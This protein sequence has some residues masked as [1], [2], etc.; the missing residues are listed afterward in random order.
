MPEDKPYL[1]KIYNFLNTAYGKEGTVSKGAFTQSYQDFES[2]ISSND[3]YKDKIYGALSNA[4][5]PSGVVR[6]NAFTSTLEAFRGKVSSTQP[7][8]NIGKVQNNIV[9]DQP[10]IQPSDPLPAHP[11]NIVGSDPVNTLLK[12]A[13]DLQ[14]PETKQPGIMAD[15]SAIEPLISAKEAKDQEM[16]DRGK[17]LLLTPKANSAIN[18]SGQPAVPSSAEMSIQD[19]LHKMDA[20]DKVL[21]T[22]QAEADEFSKTTAG[23]LYY[24]FVRPVYQSLVGT[25][26][27]LLAGTARIAGDLG[28]SFGLED[29]KKVLDKTADGLADY[30]DFNRL[31]REGNSTGYLNMTPTSQQG[32]MSKANILPKAMESITSMATLIGGGRVL[33]GNSAALYT[34]NYLATYEDFRK[35]AKQAGLSNTDADKF[36]ITSAGVNSALLMISPETFMG[37]SNGLPLAEKSVFDAIKSGV[38]VQQAVKNGIKNGLKTIGEANAIVLSTDIANRVIRTGSDLVTGQNN[39][40]E[41]SITPTLDEALETGVLTTIAMGALNGRKFGRE[42]APSSLERSA[43]V[44]AAEKPELIENAINKALETQSI[45]PAQADR[46][47]NDVAEY[48]EIYNKIKEQVLPNNPRA[49]LPRLALDAFKSK[50]QAEE[51]KPLSSIPALSAVNERI[52]SDQA[53]T[54]RDIQD[55]VNGI[56]DLGEKVSG[57]DLMNVFTMQGMEMDP[58]LLKNLGNLKQEYQ[59]DLINLDALYRN[60][61]QFRSYVDKGELIKRESNNGID[62]L[63]VINENGEIL[64]GINGLAKEY[65]DGKKN[66][67]ALL[68][69]IPKSDLIVEEPNSSSISVERNVNKPRIVSLQPDKPIISVERLKAPRIVEKISSQETTGSPDIESASDPVT[70]KTTRP[71]TAEEAK[72]RRDNAIAQLKD[73]YERLNSESAEGD[74]KN[75]LSATEQSE[76]QQTLYNAIREEMSFR[77]TAVGGVPERV[78]EDIRQKTYNAISNEVKVNE[79]DFNNA[80]ERIYKEDTAP[81]Q[82]ESNQVSQLFDGSKTSAEIATALAEMTGDNFLSEQVKSLLPYLEAN[83][84]IKFSRMYTLG[85]GEAFTTG[86]WTVNPAFTK[87]KKALTYATVHELYHTISLNELYNNQAFAD[88]IGGLVSKLRDQLG[89]T[90]Y[91]EGVDGYNYASKKNMK[92]YGLLNSAEFVSEIFSNKEFSDV[93]DKTEIGQKKPILTRVIDYVKSAIGISSKTVSSSDKIRKMILSSIKEK[94]DFDKSGDN[95]MTIRNQKENANPNNFKYTPEP[96]KNWGAKDVRDKALDKLK[97]AYNAL[98]T[99]G[100]AFDPNQTAKKQAEFNKALV[101]YIKE[102][103]LYRANQVKGFAKYTKTQVKTAV[104]R[105]MNAEGVKISMAEYTDLFND[106]YSQI[107]KIPGVLGKNVDRVT[108][109]EYFK[110]KIEAREKGR[111]E[112]FTEGRAKGMAEGKEKGLEQG[113]RKGKKEGAIEARERVKIVRGAINEVL[114]ESRVN[115][116]MLQKRRIVSMLEQATTSRDLKK[117]IDRAVDATTQMVWEQKHKAV[118]SN[119][120]KQIKAVNALKRSKSM[121][122]QDIEWLKQLQLPN[123]AKVDDLNTYQDMLKDYISSRKGDNTNPKYTKEEIAEFIQDENER[124]YQEKRQG[125]QLDMEG[126]KEKGVLPDDISL[127]E[128]IATLDNDT[129]NKLKEGISKKAEILRTET[130]SR[131]GY[132][133]DRVAEFEGNEKDVVKRLSE[134]DV[135]DLKGEELIRLNNVLNNIA[136]YGTLDAAGDIVTSYEAKKAINEIIK[137]GDKL[138]ALPSNKVL[139]KKNLSNYLSSLFYNDAAISRFR[140]KILSGIE[141]SVARTKT[142][143]QSVVKRFVELNKKNKINGL[144]NA[145]L[146]AFSYLNQY[147][148]IEPAEISDNLKQKLDE[149]IDDAKYLYEKHESLSNKSEYKPVYN[150]AI[151]R[152]DALKELGL[153]DYTIKDGK[154]SI[155]VMSDAFDVDNPVGSM[156]KLRESLSE[157]ERQV[158]DFVT[159]HYADITDNL[160]FATRTYAGKEFQRERNYVS[161]VSRPKRAAENTIGDLSDGTDVIQNFGSVNSKPANTTLSRSNAKPK[162]RYYD[163]DFFSNFVNRY[164]TSLYTINALPELQKTAKI[165]NS[166]DF[167]RFITGE[168]DPGKTMSREENYNKFKEKFAESINEEKYSPYFKRG[169]NGIAE[170]IITKGVRMALGNVF[171]GPKQYVPALLHNL[172]I[173]NAKAFAYAFASRGKAT[174]NPTYAAARKLFLENFTGVQRSALGSEAY[175]EYVKTVN[176]DATIFT[177]P[178]QLLDKAAKVSSFVL[179]RADRMAQNDAY[180]ASYATKLIRDGKIRSINDFDIAKEAANP[181]KE[182][183]AYAEQMASNINNES[184]KAY[185]PEVLKD[186]EK[187]KYLWLLQGFSLNAYQ[188]AMN[189]AKIILDNRATKSEKFEAMTHFMGYLSEVGGYQLIGLGNRAVQTAIAASLL[190]AIFGLEYNP[191]DE[192]K[193]AKRTKE[194]IKTGALM[195]GDLALSGQNAAIQTA[196]KASANYAY[197]EWAKN[198]TEGK[199]KAAKAAGGRFNPKGTH[200]S[201]TYQPYYGAEGPGGAAQFYYDIGKK[202]VDKIAKE[203]ASSETKEAVELDRSKKIA[204]QLN[205]Y[206]GLPAS[207][208]SSGDLMLLNMRMQVIL[209]DAEKAEKASSA[210]SRGR[211]GGRRARTTRT[212]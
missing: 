18:M 81:I 171:Q 191:S 99:M 116:T 162:D 137:S 114:K 26:G 125:M 146:H 138:R 140:G 179:E 151:N 12:G 148:G 117:S 153:I 89:L 95:D 123:P 60:N 212:R 103:I 43:W 97:S 102:E 193:K 5:G 40:N 79:A 132:L 147:R 19:V 159:N 165:V 187:S 2:K 84:E 166:E 104:R 172:T 10:Q 131:L 167:K 38:P 55:A 31:A 8:T 188:N 113:N 70:E 50:K 115:L 44:Q 209:K 136:E 169:K 124:I 67:R 195:L 36:A 68:E 77:G 170:K 181:D 25:G 154:L 119:V 211:S 111:R 29:S 51:T 66:S 106:A 105:A 11:E 192:D 52:K 177:K 96:V 49:D 93:V 61:P 121:V 141:K 46:I 92:Y 63:A 150:D 62:D 7:S 24:S 161:L 200:L 91:F 6:K 178:L 82:Q 65:I 186:S 85:V 98:G 94:I 86:D 126:L 109:R 129:P 101:S 110:G 37:K 190:S 22:A 203:A 53:E 149:L 182:A 58:A 194:Q 45:Q 16:F 41:R 39:F 75:F 108:L 156:D 145:K 72:I 128:Y 205:L 202:I 152:L 76:L 4:Y 160:E 57:N 173:N 34:S 118:I 78:K 27:N 180:I 107:K 185:R 199:K 15:Q 143:S 23:G 9:P 59:S 183:L 88:Q 17:D 35:Q 174:I 208:L 14:L 83:P 69:Y 175:D 47:R 42:N 127:D 164:Y 54:E 56:P 28:E 168:F 112:G 163:G 176:D 144:S 189:K 21:H 198:V 64:N 48:S 184:A 90:N 201:P 210:R 158:Y 157:G 122:L 13:K 134:I 1:K 30:F 196:L 3:K 206:L 120:K 204:E 133:N 130:K 32:A 142:Q 139:S 197:K 80:F 74:G 100:V 87:N 135:T 73:A 20:Q 155:D 71:Q 33:G 207:L